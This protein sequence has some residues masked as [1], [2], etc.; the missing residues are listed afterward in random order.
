MKLQELIDRLTVI[1]G[2]GFGDCRV[3]DN[4]GN[5]VM[6]V[7]RPIRPVQHDIDLDADAVML[8]CHIDYRNR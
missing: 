4:N 5:D 2:E 6:R 1:A 3:I 8:G 7:D